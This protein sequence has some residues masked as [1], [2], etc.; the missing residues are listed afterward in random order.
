MS[1]FLRLQQL[2]IDW[3]PA[4]VGTDETTALFAIKAGTRVVAASAEPLTNAA[5]STTSTASLGDGTSVSGYITSGSGSGNLDL[6]LSTV[7]VKVQGTGALLLA[8]LGKL[9]TVDDTVDV[10][11][12]KNTQGATNPKVRFCIYTLRER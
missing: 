12:T 2:Y 5:G 8:S 3:S 9:Y 1:N 10:V 7:G 4:A 6:E 11:Y